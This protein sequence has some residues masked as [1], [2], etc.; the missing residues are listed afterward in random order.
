M[1]RIS[2]SWRTIGRALLW[3]TLLV[4][5]GAFPVVAS[6]AEV[7]E[8]LRER[9]GS[10]F[11]REGVD[12]LD[13]MLSLS[14]TRDQARALLRQ[15]EAASR[16]HM[17]YYRAQADIQ[18]LEIEAYTAFL[19]ED[20]LNQGFKP[21]VEERTARVHRRAITAREKWVTELNALADEVWNVLTPDQQQIAESYRPNKK[22]VF[23]RFATPAER[24][25]A[26]RRA[27]QS[28]RHGPPRTEVDDPQW[29][30]ARK[31]LEALE[32]A[33]HPRP[34]VVAEYLLTP[35]A[36]EPLYELAAVSA[37]QVV[38]EAVEGRQS[39]TRTYP[40]AQHEKDER[41]LHT[42]RQEI[43]RWNLA[44]GMHFDREQIGQLVPLAEE[45]ERLRATQ[46]KAKPK[47]KLSPADF[48]AELVRLE[49]AAES[50]L[51]QGQ[52]EVLRL[53]KPCLIPPKN[54]KDPV[55]VGQASDNTRMAEWLARARGRPD[56]Q[57]ERIIDRLIEGE[58]AQLG[59]L[60]DTVLEER[61][62][63]LRETVRRA[64]EMSEVEFALNKDDLADA[65][66]P[67]DRKKELIAEIDAMRRAHRQPGRTAQF[68]LNRGF[69]E[70][71]KVRYAQL[72]GEE[73]PRSEN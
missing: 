56:R 18:P 34:D 17:D 59:P 51:H 45:A 29:A 43:N 67:E 14:L 72:S 70:V 15:Y 32:R 57:V 24:R 53:Y 47:D 66:Q 13:F 10:D 37:P 2:L 3:T 20:R 30:E 25:K 5:A 23:G 8:A 4:T 54:L 48:S 1:S 11:D 65:I 60:D 62:N 6:A 12:A 41:T 64:S 9:L 73:S 44:N 71:L 69:A 31:E 68:L 52:L 7:P 26:A 36:A 33:T 61:R 28:A 21:E 40:R 63:L 46:H 22:A 58:T 39:G 38:R 55:R 19:A 27:E 42:L 49:G 50:V 16:L 35:A